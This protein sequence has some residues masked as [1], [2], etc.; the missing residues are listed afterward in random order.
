MWRAAVKEEGRVHFKAI[1]EDISA[2]WEHI[3]K[4]QFAQ[5]C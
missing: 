2:F 4:L 3:S 5:F 1:L